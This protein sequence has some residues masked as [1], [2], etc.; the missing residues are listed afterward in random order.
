MAVLAERIRRW[1]VAPEKWVQP[2]HIAP[3]IMKISELKSLSIVEQNPHQK[4]IYVDLRMA[5][6][7]GEVLFGNV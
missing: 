6:L 1:T 3:N 5:L 4:I 7:L 2:P